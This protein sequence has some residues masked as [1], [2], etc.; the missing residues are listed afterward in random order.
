[1]VGVAPIGYLAFSAL[2]DPGAV[3]TLVATGVGRVC[4]VV[5]IGLE[6]LAALWIRRIL[7]SAG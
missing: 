7:R 3:T 2:V 4:L 6:G 1:V 5:G